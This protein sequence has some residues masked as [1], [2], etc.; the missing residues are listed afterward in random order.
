M[1]ATDAPNLFFAF[2][3]PVIAMAISGLIA[4]AVYKGLGA[5]FRP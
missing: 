3:L 1:L 4:V 2:G 5:I